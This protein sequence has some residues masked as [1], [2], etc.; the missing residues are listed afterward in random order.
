M[1][2]Y[3]MKN[4]MKQSQASSKYHDYQPVVNLRT[5]ERERPTTKGM[6]GHGIIGFL[7]RHTPC[8]QPRS[9]RQTP[10]G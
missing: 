3:L 4:L 1:T 5:S 2:E 7:L 8:G 6:V 10:C 9:A